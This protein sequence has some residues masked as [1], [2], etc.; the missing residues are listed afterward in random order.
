MFSKKSSK[1]TWIKTIF[2]LIT[3][4][5]F[6]PSYSQEIRIELARKKI[7]QNEF[8]QIRILS[9]YEDF[10]N[11]EGLPEIKDFE[12]TFQVN[13]EYTSKKGEL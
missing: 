10:K 2:Q 3:F 13:L 5:A 12:K 6:L 9:N 11:V 1:K 4:F 7:K 8:L